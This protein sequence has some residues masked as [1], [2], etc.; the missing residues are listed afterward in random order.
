MVELTCSPSSPTW[1]QYRTSPR[2]P[3][4]HSPS[5]SSFGT[6]LAYIIN[7]AIIRNEGPHPRLRRHLHRPHRLGSRRCRSHL[8]SLNPSL[9]TGTTLVLT[10]IAISRRVPSRSDS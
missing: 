10:G 9:L 8:R 2:S 1:E 3:G 6:G 4:P 5:S 7:Y